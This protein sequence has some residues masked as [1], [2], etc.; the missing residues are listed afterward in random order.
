MRSVTC[1]SLLFTS[2]SIIFAP[3][4]FASCGGPDPVPTIA[5]TPAAVVTPESS[6]QAASQTAGLIADRISSVVS[7]TAGGVGPAIFTCLG[8]GTDSTLDKRT[9]PTNAIWSGASHTR[10]KKSDQGGEYSGEIT[11]GVVGYDRRLSRDLI[12]GLAFGYERID[13]D[14]HY[15]QGNVEGD[16]LSIAPYVGY[17]ITDW[18]SVDGT[19]G[20]SWVNYDFTR[21]GNITGSAKADRWFGATNL[22]ASHRYGA[23]TL[24]TSLGYLRLHEAQDGYVESDATAVA[25]SSINFGQ[26]RATMGGGY[27]FAT[28]IGVITPNAFIRY[29]YDLPHSNAVTLGNGLVS[30][31][32]RDGIVLGLGIDLALENNLKL[33]LAGSSTEARKN[34]EAYALQANLRYSF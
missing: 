34:T 14:T 18:L 2:L 7:G 3:E 16:S 24:R 19:L 28:A 21:S 5:P 6:R 1:T 10:V 29:E 30:S 26:A 8:S 17:A 4:V 33:S 11:S 20:H 12:A 15:N 13:I 31:D 9:I 23:A 32:D 27:D 22:T 25:K